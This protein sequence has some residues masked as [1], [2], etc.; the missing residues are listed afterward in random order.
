MASPDDVF[1]MTNGVTNYLPAG[2][3][4]SLKKIL[5]KP[6]LTFISTYA[7]TE[8]DAATKALFLAY[9]FEI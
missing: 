9:F 3:I 8:A 7:F 1:L 6:R 4:D 2:D 5:S